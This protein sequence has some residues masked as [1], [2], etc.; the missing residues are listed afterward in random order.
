M[1]ISLNYSS[2]CEAL[3]AELFSEGRR[4]RGKMG[5]EHWEDETGRNGWGEKDRRWGLSWRWKEFFLELP[6]YP[7]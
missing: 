3:Q 5:R 2:Q 6:K 1:L 4:E 7:P